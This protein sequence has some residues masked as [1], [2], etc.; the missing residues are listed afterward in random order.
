MTTRPKIC[1]SSGENTM[2]F[3][4]GLAGTSVTVPGAGAASSSTVKRSRSSASTE[5]GAATSSRSAFLTGTAR[6][7]ADPAIARESAHR[8]YD[9][10]GPKQYTLRALVALA[11][12]VEPAAVEVLLA[13]DEVDREVLLRRE[14]AHLARDK[15]IAHLD[16]Q[17]QPALCPS[18]VLV[19]QHCPVAREEDRDLVPTV[20]QDARQRADGIGQAARLHVGEHFRGNVDDFHR[21]TLAWIFPDAMKYSPEGTP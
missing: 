17:R 5:S 19:L 8:N 1:T 6:A 13:A 9:L 7:I 20:R 2:G 4:R 14:H 18:G 12:A 10:G 21:S 15:H 3:N 11:G 16:L